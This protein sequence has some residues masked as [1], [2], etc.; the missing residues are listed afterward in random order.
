MAK[1][2]IKQ[3]GRIVCISGCA[4]C[5]GARR[6]IILYGVLYGQFVKNT[7]LLAWFCDVRI[8]TVERERDLIIITSE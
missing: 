2:R 8:S 6:H 1:P 4:W 5:K 7:I 3:Q